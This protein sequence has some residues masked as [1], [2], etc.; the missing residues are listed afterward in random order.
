MAAVLED[1]FTGVKELLT[2]GA[3]TT[4]YQLLE[5]NQRCAH[6]VL[7]ATNTAE[8]AQ[9]NQRLEDIEKEIDDMDKL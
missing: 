1:A 6:F 8:Q 5:Y 9:N 3:V 7:T 4:Y 2:A